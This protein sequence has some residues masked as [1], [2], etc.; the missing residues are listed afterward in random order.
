MSE[1]TANV[2]KGSECR[3]RVK[4]RATFAGIALIHRA[5]TSYD[6]AQLSVSE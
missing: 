5:N 1:V 2:D 4:N 3:P 6:A